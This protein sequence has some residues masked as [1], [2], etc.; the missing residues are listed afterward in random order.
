MILYR[1]ASQSFIQWVFSTML[2]FGYYSN[3]VQAHNWRI[4]STKK[5]LPRPNSL[6]STRFARIR[7]CVCVCTRACAYVRVCVCVLLH[8]RVRDPPCS[9]QSSSSDAE[10]RVDELLHAVEHLQ[11][12]LKE[13]EEE[14]NAATEVSRRAVEEQEGGRAELGKGGVSI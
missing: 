11:Q 7:V 14:K 8:Q 5:L 3:A 6:I 10:R 2:L 13:A 9:L 12:M 1:K 4:S